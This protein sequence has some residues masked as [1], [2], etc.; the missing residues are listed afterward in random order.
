LCVEPLAAEQAA[1]FDRCG[2][3]REDLA[4]I[5]PPATAPLELPPEP[6]WLVVHSGPAEEVAQ[7]VAYAAEARAIEGVALPLVVI[8]AQAPPVL[9]PNTTVLD[10]FPATPYFAGA[11]RIFSAAGFNIVRQAALYRAKH[12][13]LPMPR[14]FDDQFARAARV[15]VTPI[16]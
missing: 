4:L 16:L 3:A 5:D 15:R 8:A 13:L 14:R 7:L 1:W 11:A 10:V 9:P 12:V 2:W 6:Y